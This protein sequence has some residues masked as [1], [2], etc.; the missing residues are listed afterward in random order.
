MIKTILLSVTIAA[1]FFGTGHTQA[2]SQ[3]LSANRALSSKGK[4]AAPPTAQRGGKQVDATATIVDGSEAPVATVSRKGIFNLVGLKHDHM[5]DIAV[6]YPVSKA[7]HVISA[8]PLDGGQ[9]IASAKS[10]IVGADGT[11]HL[12]FRAGHEVGMYQIALHDRA[13]ELGLQFWVLDELHPEKNR[14]VVNPS[15]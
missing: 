9:V 12:K 8:E 1:S 4:P 13:E 15:K 10:L 5:V 11:I 2:Q 3:S 7:G 6:Q 14:Q